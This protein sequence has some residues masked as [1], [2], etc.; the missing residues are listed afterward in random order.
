MLAVPK[1]GGAGRWFSAQSLGLATDFWLFFWELGYTRVESA[2]E[3]E[4]KSPGTF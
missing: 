3:Q 4:S 1:K 2:I